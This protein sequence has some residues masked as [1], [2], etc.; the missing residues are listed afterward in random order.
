V[1]GYDFG[2]SITVSK[3]INDIISIM[4]DDVFT[5]HAAFIRKHLILS[6]RGAKGLRKSAKAYI[7]DLVIAWA[8]PKNRAVNETIRLQTVEGPRISIDEDAVPDY[9]F[10]SKFMATWVTVYVAVGTDLRI[11]GFNPNMVHSVMLIAGRSEPSG[12]AVNG[13]Y[14][15]KTKQIAISAK[16]LKLTK[17]ALDHLEK[18]WRG[19]LLPMEILNK[20]K[21]NRLWE[22]LFSLSYPASTLIHELEHA[23]RATSGHDTITISL[24]PGEPAVT[25]SYDE[26]ANEV[27]KKI[28]NAGFYDRLKESLA[29][30]K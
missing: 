30:S 16:Y 12:H 22:P 28:I 25:L 13:W 24:T 19:K 2:G 26:T 9:P 8:K 10:L 11:V 6:L 3:L 14:D 4:N 21:L 18:M 17:V 7:T 5:K 27:Y 1:L 20:L 15:G 29:I 23:R